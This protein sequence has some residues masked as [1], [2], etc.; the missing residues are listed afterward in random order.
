VTWRGAIVRSRHGGEGGSGDPEF[1][2]LGRQRS[3]IVDDGQSVMMRSVLDS[4]EVA[5]DRV[6][7]IRRRGL[8]KADVMHPHVTP[9]VAVVTCPA[10]L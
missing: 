7:F 1:G 2:K 10:T 6:A 9:R 5:V 4:A 8:Y 3:I